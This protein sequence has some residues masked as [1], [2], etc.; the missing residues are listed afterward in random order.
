M[1]APL[2]LVTAC[3]PAETSD[4][5]PRAQESDEV[6]LPCIVNDTGSAYWY[7]ECTSEA[8]TSFSGYGFYSLYE[9]ADQGDGTVWD[10]EALS[11]V[12]TLGTGDGR[13]FEFGGSAYDLTVTAIGGSYVGY[14]NV[15]QGRFS[16]D[17]A[18]AV[19]TWL[20][21]GDGADM[22]QYAYTYADYGNIRY[23]DGSVELSGELTTHAV[24]D[25]LTLWPES[26]SLD[27]RE[28]GGTISVR[29]PT[30]FGTT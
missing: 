27:C 5:A 22:A 6:P 9:G 7:D 21:G 3:G 8:G 26:I 2:L 30:G 29:T 17:G 18:E 10:G 13:T 24:F 16:W 12:A 14:Y 20:E 28:P 1:T 11:G 4:S 15:V 25:L 23:L 19:G